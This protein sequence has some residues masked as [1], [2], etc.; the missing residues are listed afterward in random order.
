MF[1]PARCRPA[2]CFAAVAGRWEVP[3]VAC[4]LL[5]RLADVTFGQSFVPTIFRI[6]M[7]VWFGNF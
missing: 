4:C 3:S 7:F 5:A 1:G 2:K 6:F